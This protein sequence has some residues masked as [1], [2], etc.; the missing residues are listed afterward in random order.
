[1]IGAA[2]DEV[3]DPRLR[4]R[5]GAGT[6]GCR[7]RAGDGGHAHGRGGR[8][9]APQRGR[10]LTMAL[11]EV[12]DL[13]VEFGVPGGTARA[14][15]GI[16]FD[17]DAGE[18]VGLVGESGCG[19]TTTALAIMRLLPENGRLARGL[20]PVR[21]RGADDP[22]RRAAFRARRWTQMSIIFQG[23]MNALNPVRRVGDQVLEPIALHEPSVSRDAA[24][25]RVGELF[26][27]VGINPERRQEYPHQFSGGM[28]QR[29]MIAMAL[30]CRPRLVIGDEPTT[31][32]DVMVQAQILELL[33]T[34][35]AR[36]GPG[37][38]PHHPRPVGGRRDLRPGRRD[39]RR[40]ARRDRIRG[41]APRPAA[42]SLQ[43]PPAGFRARHPGRAGP[44][45]GHP[46]SAAQPRVTGQWLP[47][48]SPLRPRDGRCVTDVP[49]ER[50][51]G[52]AHRV[53]CHAV[54]ADGR[55][56]APAR[57]AAAGA[58]GCWSPR[59]P[60]S[61]AEVADECDRD[62]GARRRGRPDPG[63]GC[64]SRDRAP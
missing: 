61:G 22:R 35:A 60:R 38:H 3:F 33:E 46:R 52:A 57:A 34:P 40:T 23:A 44:A 7:E 13:V 54:T 17:V 12:R 10:P 42:P 55:L 32:L 8:G 18:A 25:T 37:H 31:A 41:P 39:V 2:L 30:A 64:P 19:K 50:A 6:T 43:R 29:V 4:R 58:R 56:Q 53:A 63:R 21:R 20:H 5:H 27:M 51:F 16:S 48:P 45:P 62:T 1:M 24:W 36:A 26:E 59:P 14:V 9:R 49:E 11:L 28:R 15:D 47:V